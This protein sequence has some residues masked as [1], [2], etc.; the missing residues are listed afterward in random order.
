MMILS[1]N[2]CVIHPGE[3]MVD[4]AHYPIRRSQGAGWGALEVIPLCR[5]WH[6]R[7]DNHRL[8]LVESFVLH[9]VADEYLRRV[10]R[11]YKDDPK[12]YLGPPET[13]RYYEQEIL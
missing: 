7:Y 9:T 11:Q 5:R 10:Y 2:G 4:P 12:V 3:Y 13:A 8:T 6:D 1:A